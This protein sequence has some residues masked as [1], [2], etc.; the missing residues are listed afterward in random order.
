MNSAQKAILT[1][2]ALVLLVML[3]FP[4]YAVLYRGKIVSPLG[5]GTE[6]AT[7]FRPAWSAPEGVDPDDGDLN[8]GLPSGQ[9]LEA[10]INIGLLGIEL[11]AASIITGAAV[12]LARGGKEQKP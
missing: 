3:L 8:G 1:I 7:V 2:G 6:E 9:V 11:L 12:M 5:G 10:E 4:P